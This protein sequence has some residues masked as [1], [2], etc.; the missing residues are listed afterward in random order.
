MQ[1]SSEGIRMQGVDGGG[2]DDPQVRKNP[3]LGLTWPFRPEKG[4][5]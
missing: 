1:T 3:R 2:T 4:D 5:H